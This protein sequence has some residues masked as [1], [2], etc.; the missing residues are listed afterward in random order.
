MLFRSTPI[1]VITRPRT[2]DAVT[3]LSIPNP[4][5]ANERFRSD[6]NNPERR[7]Y[8]DSKNLGLVWNAAKWIAPY[9]NYSTSY[10][11]P[12]SNSLDILFENI[13]P[14]ESFGYDMGANLR[15]LKGNLTMRLNYYKNSR[16]YNTGNSPV[17]PVINLLYQSNRFDD[18]IGR[19]HV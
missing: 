2:T 5:F 9:L 18:K 7:S 11:P 17:Q 12:A 10:T 15:F 13:R 16:K 1:L 3:G 4:T 19:A 14:L 6:Y 8:S